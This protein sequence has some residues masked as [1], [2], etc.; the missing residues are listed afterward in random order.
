[1]ATCYKCPKQRGL[2]AVAETRIAEADESKQHDRPG[3]RLGA[4][5]EIELINTFPEPLEI[6]EIEPRREEVD[7]PSSKPISPGSCAPSDVA[8][9]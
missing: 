2:W 5:P 9:L 3:R 1:M 7:T 4:C 6:D 8:E